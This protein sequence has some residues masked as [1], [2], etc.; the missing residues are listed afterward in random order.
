MSTADEDCPRS[1]LV[2]ILAAWSPAQQTTGSDHRPSRRRAGRAIPGGDRRRR[3]IRTP[4]SAREV[5]SD[6]DGIYRLAALPVGTYAA[7]G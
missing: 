2:L 1:A 4:D 7:V 3:P 5:A 6:D